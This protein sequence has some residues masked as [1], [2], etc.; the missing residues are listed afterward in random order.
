[1]DTIAE[2][3]LRSRAPSSLVEAERQQ[4]PGQAPI[5]YTQ[6]S[7]R[8]RRSLLSLANG[9]F[10]AMIEIVIGI[11]YLAVMGTLGVLAAMSVFGA[12]V[13]VGTLGAQV[14]MSSLTAAGAIASVSES[15]S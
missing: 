7:W 10:G 9:L 2:L 8:C 11:A 1:M 15:V 5:A 12:D 3:R 6:G 14:G 13:V 4:R